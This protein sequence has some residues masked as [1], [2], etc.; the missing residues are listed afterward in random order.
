MPTC[1]V[2]F[3]SVPT[4]IDSVIQ[5]LDLTLSEK[6][7]RAGSRLG[8]LNNKEPIQNQLEKQT[9]EKGL[10]LEFRKD[11]ERLLLA[12][13]QKPDGKKNWMVCDQNGVVCSI[14]P[15]QVT[16]IV[17]GIF[18]FDHTLIAD[19]YLKTQQLLDPDILE[20][21]WEEILKSKKAVTA[22]DLAKILYGSDESF[23]SYCAHLLLSKDEIYFTVA[24]G[25][26][27]YCLYEARPLV[28]VEQL[29]MRKR[30]KEAYEKELDKFVKLLMFAKAS[31]HCSKPHKSSWLLEDKIHGRIKALENY[32]IDYC[33]NA[34]E[35]KIGRKD[36][37]G[38]GVVKDV[39]CCSKFADR[40][41]IFSCAC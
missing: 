21:A 38:N 7:V 40:C 6:K 20:C 17:P 31:D 33:K 25:K 18:D 11:A 41:W 32:A 22:A 15:Q 26:G 13:A 9:L 28:Q 3:F 1:C 27:S 24:E 12:V 35:K 29:R 19:F 23:R 10:L 16:Y 2:R 4:Q 39:N 14:K 5:E 37:A 36:I 8:F 34:E 30:V